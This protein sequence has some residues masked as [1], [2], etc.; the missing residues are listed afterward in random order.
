MVNRSIAWCVVLMSSLRLS[1]F[2]DEEALTTNTGNPLKGIVRTQS[3]LYRDAVATSQSEPVDVFQFYYVLPTES[4]GKEKVK[5]GFIRV[6]TAA[7]GPRQAGW[8]PVEASVDW[9][10]AQV[11]GF[12]PQGG[13]GRVLFFA[14]QADAGAWL[15]G[16]KGS[17]QKAM[18]QEPSSQVS[19]L[20]PLLDVQTIEHDGQKV[21]VYKLAY[22][23]GSATGSSPS[24]TARAPSTSD[25]PSSKEPMTRKKLQE[26]FLLQVAF[27]IDTTASMQPWIEA[28]KTVI[29]RVTQEVSNNPAL[30]G[31]V[32][33]GLVG[34]RDE[35][36]PSTPSEVREQM[37]Y[38]AKLLCDLTSDHDTFKQHLA[39][40]REASVGSEDHP[41]DGLAGLKTGVQNLNWKKPAMKVIVLIGDAPFHTS[42]DGYKNIH[43]LTI[44]GLLALAQPT[45]ADYPR[46]VGRGS[47]RER[48]HRQII[49][50][51]KNHG[52][53]RKR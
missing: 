8:I 6:A 1:A 23:N 7:R 19:S 53:S 52:T 36:E 30:K 5:N 38:V 20:F 25:T 40:V 48:T 13:R 50:T 49:R 39:M 3:A 10:H 41:E 34:Y 32:E 16:T 42:T 44:P 9:P 26:S 2:A 47:I 37:E 4:N 11:V 28:V 12:T 24:S 35:L 45:G 46:C 17:E 51:G 21:D 33:F 29:G 18:S 31:R 22:L 43:K 27:V 14:S 15:K